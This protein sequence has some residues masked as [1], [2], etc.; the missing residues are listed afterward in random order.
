MSE[1][2][3]VCSVFQVRKMAK[4]SEVASHRRISCMDQTWYQIPHV[5]DSQASAP[6]LAWNLSWVLKAGVELC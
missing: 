2:D 6:P 1:I 5:L 4:G 3:P